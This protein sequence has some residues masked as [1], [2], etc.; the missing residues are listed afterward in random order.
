MQ[1]FKAF[2]LEGGNIRV[3]PK[4]QETSAAPFPVTA[5]TRHQV[6]SDIHNALASMGDSFHKEHGEHLFGQDHQRLH[7]A[8]AFTGSTHDLMGQHVSHAE[9]AKHKPMVGDVDTQVTPEHKDKLAA[10]LTPGRKFGKYTVVG[11]KKHGNEISAVMRHENGEHHQFDF[12]GVSHPGSESSRFLH[13]SSWQ[14]TSAGIKGAH[15]KILLNAIGGDTHKFSITH[16]LRSRT[17]ESDPGVQHPRDVTRRLFGS[18]ADHNDIHS[19]H[20][21]TQL[22]KKHIPK[23]QHQAIYDKFKGSVS[24][25][26]GM[27]HGPALAHMRKHLGV[28]DTVNEGFLDRFKRRPAVEAP[29]ER[30]PN[31][32]K[33]NDWMSQKVAHYE[34][35]KP[36]ELHH[37]FS[38]ASGDYMPK[39][40]HV[41]SS[42]KK[43]HEDHYNELKKKH[44]EAVAKAKE[45][46]TGIAGRVSLS[47]VGPNADFHG[48][49]IHEAMK[50][51]PCWTGYEMIGKKKKNGREVPNCVKEEEEHHVHVSYLGASPFPHMGHHTDIGGSMNAA[52]HG[53]KFIGLSGKSDA[54]S[55]KE[56]EDI[57][58]KQSG[59]KIDFQ[60]VK[61]PGVTIAKARNSMP[62]TGRKVLHLHFG[63]DRRDFA[64]KLKASVENGKI[65]ELNGQKFDEVNVH[66]P[67][68]ENRSHGMSGTKMRTAASEG[69]LNTFKKH[70]GPNFSDKEAKSLMDRT[71][72]SLMAGKIKVKR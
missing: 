8:T 47:R 34:R 19:F 14:D 38:P 39:D 62:A 52:P 7:D 46:T 10:H 25:M 41:G 4:G 5:G 26:K 23:D 35:H 2:I 9:F 24:K 16:G 20:G 71:R 3:G 43:E 45:M 53:K 57:A 65:P 59:G 49:S 60:T 11:T 61:S 69:D 44:P 55:D 40:V 50:D 67:K 6:R 72:V 51:D 1:R 42:W 12:Q 13:G 18:N 66:L 48:M 54:F 70:V 17:D 58:N 28:R 29:K 27:D 56:R 32:N 68:D 63:H 37:L 21:V 36:S 33:A 15:H 30:F 31:S 64:E 22:I